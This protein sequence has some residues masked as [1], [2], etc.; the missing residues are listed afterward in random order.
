MARPSVDDD[1]RA[2]Q[3]V[4]AS[5]RKDASQLLKGK[6]PLLSAREKEDDRAAADDRATAL[7]D[8]DG[9]ALA[10]SAPLPAPRLAK[11]ATATTRLLPSAL[12]LLLIPLLLA[13]L[14]HLPW[15]PRSVDAGG[16]E[17]GFVRDPRPPAD[18]GPRHD[19]PLWI[20]EV[21]SFPA[22]DGTPLEA[23]VY[24]PKKKSKEGG[25][26]AKQ[27]Q[28][29]QQQQQKGQRAAPPPPPPVV[30]IGQGLGA[31]KDM[32]LPAYSE[33]FAAA[34]FAVMA[35][36]Y[37]GFG[38]SGGEPRHWVD[39][40]RH[41]ADWA[42]AVQFVGGGELAGNANVTRHA[43][44]VLGDEWASSS[45]SSPPPLLDGSRV[46]LWGMSYSGG[47]VLV[48]AATPGMGADTGG[49][50]RAVISN[51]PFLT[52][53]AALKRAPLE[54]GALRV[55]RLFLAAASD[56]LR[57]RLGLPA[58]YVR[59]AAP[60]S[61][62]KALA[63]LQLKDS[64][65]VAQRDMAAQRAAAQARSDALLQGKTEQQADEAASE[66]ARRMRA[67]AG[68][69]RPARQGGWR[70]VIAARFLAAM[71]GYEPLRAVPNVR[72]PVYLRVATLDHICPPEV[73]LE[74]A[75]LFPLAGGK[76]G[77]GSGGGSGGGG[78][79]ATAELVIAESPVT[80]IEALVH[81][82]R[83]E[84]IA[85]VVAFLRRHL[86]GAE[87]KRTAQQEDVLEAMEG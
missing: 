79:S 26:D 30:V 57:Q 61:D 69:A 8:A 17:F 29:Q 38:G 12:L 7:A 6:E 2:V 77:G 58:V 45:S 66:A 87:E 9:P 10:A 5:P 70:N 55:L 41:V 42:A 48:T 65:L 81:G 76:G 13:I 11:P 37:R 78:S 67:A 4:D 72:V 50:V 68:D 43:A 82:A 86:Q 20:R 3:E 75:R 39:P 32:G 36:D 15:E 53:K 60:I 31:Q 84:E 51:E 80:H 56:L 74:A 35:F 71:I 23:W 1:V 46:A 59:L 62:T 22:E 21:V 44:A 47:H 64:D 83:P 34:G 24:L 63:V 85:P 19:H 25:E 73:A 40:R 27:Q 49:P 16:V 18:A 28:K 54:R 14:I 33:Q 52:G